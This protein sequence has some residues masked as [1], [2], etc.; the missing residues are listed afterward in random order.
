MLGWGYNE[1]ENL[2]AYL[3]R[4]EAFLRSI[5][6]D[7]ELVLVNDGS[8]DQTGDMMDRA[9]TTRPWL[10]VLHNDR[11]RGAAYSA[12]RAIRAATKDYVFWQTLDWA[13]DIT[14]LA[15]AFPRLEQ[16]DILQGV[17]IN[18]LTATAFSLRSVV[19]RSG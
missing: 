13:Y 1:Q 6:H 2:A 15:G 9:R 7:F 14:Q 10:H 12:K 11:N 5:A 18:A 3:E 19:T 16:V 8:A 4:A 17:R